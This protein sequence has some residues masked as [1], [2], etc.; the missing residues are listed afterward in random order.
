[1][2]IVESA[3]EQVAVELHAGLLA[4]PWCGGELRPWG[5]GPWRVLG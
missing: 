1:M 2:L 5:Y 3:E 4:C